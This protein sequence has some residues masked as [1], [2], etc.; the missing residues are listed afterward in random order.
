MTG[1]LHKLKALEK[2]YGKDVYDYLNH[3]MKKE[4]YEKM[5]TMINQACVPLEKEEI[6]SETPALREIRAKILGKFQNLVN[7]NLVMVSC[8]Y[9]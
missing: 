9:M 2:A 5:V 6:E 1:R 8:T 3:R 7:F 4:G